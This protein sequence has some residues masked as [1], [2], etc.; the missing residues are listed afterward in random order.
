MRRITPELDNQLGQV[1]SHLEKLYL[2]C[3]DWTT[4]FSMRELSQVR[5]LDDGSLN[6]LE[7]LQL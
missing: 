1:V 6:D 4:Y 3:L 5:V 7:R 2:V